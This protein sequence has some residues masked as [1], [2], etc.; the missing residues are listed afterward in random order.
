[1][2]VMH[3][4]S[5]LELKQYYSLEKVSFEKVET[6]KM[7]DFHRGYALDWILS[8]CRLLPSLKNDSVLH[9]D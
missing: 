4:I 9:M 7:S 6:Y 3:S 5:R 1:M 2:T 8:C